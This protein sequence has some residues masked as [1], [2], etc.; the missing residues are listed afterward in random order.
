MLTFVNVL[1]LQRSR[2]IV[3]VEL[4]RRVAGFLRK[5]KYSLLAYSYVVSFLNNC[6][7]ASRSTCLLLQ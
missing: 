3:Q 4:E 1:A 2:V 6:C 7:S 5:I